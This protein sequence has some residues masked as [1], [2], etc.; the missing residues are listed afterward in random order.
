MPP[1]MEQSTLSVMELNDM[2]EENQKVTKVV[3]KMTKRLIGL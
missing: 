1:E 2:I 3:D